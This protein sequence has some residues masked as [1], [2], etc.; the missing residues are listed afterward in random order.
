MAWSPKRNKNHVNHRQQNFAG[1]FCA[2][3]TQK[4]KVAVK[5]V[6]FV[7]IVAI[8][9][10]LPQ[11][12]SIADYLFVNMRNR[13]RGRSSER[14]VA[15]ENGDE[16][17]D[18]GAGDDDGTLRNRDEA[19]TMGTFTR[20]AAAA[21][22][23]MTTTT[24]TTTKN[25]NNKGE[26]EGE[27]S[28]G[29]DDFSARGDALVEEEEE[30]EGGGGD[31]EAVKSDIDNDIEHDVVRLETMITDVVEVEVE[32]TTNDDTENNNNNNNNKNNNNNNNKEEEEDASV[33]RAKQKLANDP[34]LEVFAKVTPALE[35]NITKAV[36]LLEE[37]GSS[38][39]D[40]NDNDNNNNDEKMSLKFVAESLIDQIFNAAFVVGNNDNVV[41]DADSILKKQQESGKNYINLAS[42]NA[43]SSTADN[44]KNNK[45][46]QEILRKLLPKL[47]RE[48]IA[49]A[50]K[51]LNEDE[52]LANLIF[53]KKPEVVDGIRDAGGL[54]SDE[55]SDAEAR[56]MIERRFAN[57]YADSQSD[58]LANDVDATADAES[59]M[60]QLDTEN[61]LENEKAPWDAS[62][63]YANQN[64]KRERNGL[65]Y[66]FVGDE[67]IPVE[68]KDSKI[69]SEE[70]KRVVQ[71]ERAEKQ[72]AKED[73]KEWLVSKLESA[74][75]S[76]ATALAIADGR[77]SDVM[78][79]GKMSVD[80]LV[81]REK[82]LREERLAEIADIEGVADQD[83]IDD[84]E[85]D[86]NKELT[87]FDRP[88]I[89]VKLSHKRFVLCKKEQDE[90]MPST[91]GIPLPTL[92]VK[93]YLWKPNPNPIPG[94]EEFDAGPIA[95]EAAVS[96]NAKAHKKSAR[97]RAPVKKGEWGT[98]AVVGNSGLLRLSE[99]GKSI[100]SHDV[101][102]RLNQAPQRGY[103]R[104]VGLKV[105]HRVLNRLWTR[106][107]YSGASK[108]RNKAVEQH[109][110][111][112]GLTL[113]ISR[114]T[115]KEYGNLASQLAET[116]KDILAVRISS[117][118]TSM[119][120]PILEHYRERLCRS[121]FGPY[122]GLNVPSSGWV[123]ANMLTSLC[124]KVT[125][126]GFGVEGLAKFS[127]GIGIGVNETAKDE[128]HAE[129]NYHYFHGLGA[130]K[131]GNDVH[132][133]DNEERSFEALS[134]PPSEL[135]E[136]CKYRDDGGDRNWNCGCQHANV[137]KCRLEM[138]E[139]EYAGMEE[140]TDCTPGEDCPEDEVKKKAALILQEA[141]RETTRKDERSSASRSSS[142][143][144]SS[145]SS[146]SF[147]SSSGGRSRREG[148]LW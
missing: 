2:I 123:C 10:C 111:E 76:Q 70:E 119:A 132:C 129:L 37:N 144:S 143:S 101:V 147:S 9:F 92:P 44:S 30:E 83:M 51:K 47:L 74:G 52:A 32:R 146:S 126:Y 61:L 27:E 141:A 79:A 54:R 114:A 17:N 139:G 40:D 96:S 89:K 90:E 142:S 116:R 130:R 77:M 46:E 112:Q 7:T 82:R 68:Q 43:A 23:R 48:E 20:D 6:I 12:V 63:E 65:E 103:S 60:Q 110:L 134:K 45:K 127:R 15:R 21:D 50:K 22:D 140:T 53:P 66:E 24:T 104:R 4:R 102:V 106:N 25:N 18:G 58:S 108:L 42:A 80:E 1:R 117:R 88:S 78:K 97:Q 34:L 86:P 38:N 138:L 64:I 19:R 16:R 95:L 11:L 72:E 94:T 121:G 57:A 3:S 35:A 98:C 26:E 93:D 62:E 55:I 113:L 107:Y 125:V 8:I 122:K 128:K 85:E 115:L 99:Y 118:A 136:F 36:S 100:D 33:T 56:V 133:F 105:T 5:R 13:R 87:W 145:R 49:L 73:R 91:E 71:Y 29:V 39:G 148:P 109:P 28:A 124:S 137:E 81:Q 41:D 69:R 84:G 31:V 59:K 135:W 75:L 14:D 120:A 131:E 67:W